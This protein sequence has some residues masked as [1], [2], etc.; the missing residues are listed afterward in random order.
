MCRLLVA[1][2]KV[3][4]SYVSVAVLQLRNFPQFYLFSLFKMKEAKGHGATDMLQQ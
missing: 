3:D 4:N 1:I 2:D